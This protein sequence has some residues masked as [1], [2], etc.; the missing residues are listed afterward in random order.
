VPEFV[1]RA[2]EGAF[3]AGLLAREAVETAGA[4][5]V[6]V[7]D[8]GEALLGR[9][10]A[11][12]LLQGRREL[13]QGVVEELRFVG[14]EEPNAPGGLGD[15]ADEEDPGGAAGPEVVEKGREGA[16]AFGLLFRREDEFLGM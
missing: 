1:E 12:L 10:A 4:A 2:V 7:I 13:A 3:E 6:G 8:G 5:G 15:L 14:A 9:E 16:V 11:V